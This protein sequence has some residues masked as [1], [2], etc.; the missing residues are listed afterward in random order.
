ML[1]FHWLPAVLVGSPFVLAARMERDASPGEAP[2]APEDEVAGLVGRV[3]A[4][5]PAAESELVGHFSHG[6]LLMLRRLVRNPALADDLHQETFALSSSGKIRRGEVREP[7]KLAQRPRR[8]LF[9]CPL[10]R[11]PH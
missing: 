1:A 4:G 3:Q 2:E 6:L 8:P 9:S 7:E 10:Y 5:D 11:L